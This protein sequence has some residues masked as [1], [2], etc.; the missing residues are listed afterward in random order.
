MR[1]ILGLL[2]VIGLLATVFPATVTAAKPIRDSA[3]RSGILCQFSSEA[4]FISVYVDVSEAGGFADLG[5]WSPGSDPLEDVPD[6]LTSLGTASFD[7]SRLIADF[8]L[9][10]VEEPTNPEDP[11]T[12]EP[13]GTASLAAILTPTGERIDDPDSDRYGNVLIRYGLSQELMTVE[14]MLALDLLDG[15]AETVEILGCGASTTI[16]TVFAT[17]P[18]AFVLDGDQQFIECRW[19]TEQGS[20]ELRGLND[21][22]VGTF[23]ELIIVDGDGFTVGLTVPEFSDRVY[24]AGYELFD[25]ASGE[26]LGSATAHASLARSSDRVNDQEWVGGMRFSL[27]G[28]R[29][30]VDG[31]LTI[32]TED[33]STTFAMDDAVCGATD[34]RVRLIEK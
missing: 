24:L 8:E 15:T 20:V 33:G 3:S 1:R 28:H 7:G 6:I 9:V 2:A 12:L 34:L 19:A 30:T 26:A 23:S 21:S 27:V 22:L 14:G 5:L 32:T 16:E 10:S 31:T 4:G 11:P 13:A 18:N 29:L 25:P 17:N